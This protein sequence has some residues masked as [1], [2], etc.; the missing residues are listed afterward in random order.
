MALMAPAVVRLAVSIA[1]VVAGDK[2]IVSARAL[3]CVL[4]LLKNVIAKLFMDCVV[5]LYL[6]DSNETTAVVR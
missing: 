6:S 3:A 2:D 4:T 1:S 5:A